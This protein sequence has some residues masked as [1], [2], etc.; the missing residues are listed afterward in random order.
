MKKVYSLWGSNPR[1]PACEAGVIA[2]R[3]NEQSFQAYAFYRIKCIT[4]LKP[5]KFVERKREIMVAKIIAFLW[6]SFRLRSQVL[7]VSSL[8]Q[9]LLLPFL[10]WGG[11]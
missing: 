5:K 11:M 7:S 9:L 4:V 8:F 3:P 2:A 10:S 1:P 6:F